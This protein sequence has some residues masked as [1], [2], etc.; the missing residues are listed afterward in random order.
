MSASI[1]V[2]PMTIP[3]AVAIP[4]LAAQAITALVEPAT[5]VG[6]K[7]SETASPTAAQ[8]PA[9]RQKKRPRHWCLSCDKRASSNY[10]SEK[11][12][13]YCSKHR[14]PGMKDVRTKKCE[15]EGCDKCPSYNYHDRRGLCYCAEHA[16]PGMVNMRNGF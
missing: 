13:I 12:A 11:R 16:L 3:T 1:A 14:L 8:P 15:H 2:I 4:P 10:P 7:R 6:T 5:P 9:K